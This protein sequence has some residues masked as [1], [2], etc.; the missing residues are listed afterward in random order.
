MTTGLVDQAVNDI[1]EK[2][3][4]GVFP[5]LSSIPKESELADS[6]GISRLT[7]R[8]AVKILRDR[9]VLKV[10]HGK[11]TFVADPNTWNDMSTLLDFKSRRSNPRDFG[12][13]L[14]EIRCLLEVGAAELAALNHTPEDLTA[15]T[16]KLDAYDQAIS[17]G[18]ILKATK[19]DIEFHNAVFSASKNPF[20]KVILQPLEKAMTHNRIVT[21]KDAETRAKAR[22]FH[23]KIQD[24]IASG[25]PILAKNTMLAHMEQTRDSL[26]KV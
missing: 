12:L 15:M 6:L 26:E 18:D 2:I 14:L 10:I 24:A 5:P 1:L 20:I 3:L 7:L 23:H 21:T 25:N 16:E 11:G 17:E 13:K 9:G 4:D 19:E 8:E 22:M